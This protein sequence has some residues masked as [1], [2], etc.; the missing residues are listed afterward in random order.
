MANYV[1]CQKRVTKQLQCFFKTKLFSATVEKRSCPLQLIVGV[2]SERKKTEVAK[3]KL[4][5]QIP[6]LLNDSFCICKRADLITYICKTWARKFGI[7]FGAGLWVAI[8]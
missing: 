1:Q 8:N 3:T 7:N 4:S 6:P 2:N 5:H